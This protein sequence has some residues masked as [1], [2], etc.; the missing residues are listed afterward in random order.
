MRPTSLNQRITVTA[1]ALMALMV[2]VP[3]GASAQELEATAEAAAEDSADVTTEKKVE[4]EE[5]R[6]PY[7]GTS[8]SYINAVSARSFN[9]NYEPTYNPEYAMGLGI[10]AAWSFNKIFGVNAGISLIREIT[11]ADYTTKRGETWVEDLKLGVTARNFWTV[12]VLE[13]KTSAGLGIIAPTSK[14]SQ[15]NTLILGLKPNLSLSRSFEI[16]SGLNL[17]YGFAFTK[18][19]HEYTTRQFEESRIPGISAEAFMNAGLRNGSYNF[20]NSFAAS[21]GITEWMSVSANYALIHAFLYEQESVDSFEDEA[22]GTTI[23][24]SDIGVPNEN[25]RYFNVFG[26]RVSF[27]PNPAFS[28]DLGVDTMAP[29]RKPDST[30]QSPIFN[31]NTV[32]SLG[33]NLDIAGLVSELK[34]SEE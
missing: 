12:P 9:K 4:P 24:S 20:S 2:M 23:E 27:T 32:V 19:F 6:A 21:L 16:L 29:M 17:N 11:N 34:G 30:Y 8:I 26:A 13:I 28:I 33:L 5:W 1:L 10:T 14:T 15:A 25:I 18:N 31:R 7:A 3:A 22:L